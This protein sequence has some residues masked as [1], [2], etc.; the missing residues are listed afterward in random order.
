[1]QGIPHITL[2]CV[3]GVRNQQVQKSQKPKEGEAAM[4]RPTSLSDLEA[5]ARER[6]AAHRYPNDYHFFR[7]FKC[8]ACGVVAFEM[9]IGHHTGSK[10]GDFKGVIWGECV[11]CGSKK[12]LF[13]FTGKHRKRLR[14]EKPVC[15]C[16]NRSFVVA[17]CERIEGDEG[18]MGFFDEGV[19]VGNCC[20][21][22]RNRAF[23]YTD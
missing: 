19:V 23:V 14:E 16:G 3:E 10:K 20:R 2:P 5:F 6:I 7:P 21:C 4:K 13:S 11:E 8:D 18:V 22:G 12:R 9:T 1:M 15:E 17:E